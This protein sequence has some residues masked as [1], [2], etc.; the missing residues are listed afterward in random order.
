MTLSP[1]S[2]IWSFYCLNFLVFLLLNSCDAPI[3]KNRTVPIVNQDFEVHDPL[4][5]DM[6]QATLPLGI[7]DLHNIDIL[8]GIDAYQLGSLKDELDL[9]LFDDHGFFYNDRVQVMIS[10]RHLIKLNKADCHQ[11]TLYFL[12]GYLAK[13]QLLANADLTPGLLQTFGSPNGRNFQETSRVINPEK[14]SGIQTI[15]VMEWM[16]FHT[17]LKYQEKIRQVSR[18]AD[19]YLKVNQLSIELRHFEKQ[20]AI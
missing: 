2:P 11:L 12:D 7:Q 15:L 6:K 16:T 9:T 17:K 1:T 14:W 18:V 8:N 13:V 10:P 4:V 5:L 19:H 3:P 20:I